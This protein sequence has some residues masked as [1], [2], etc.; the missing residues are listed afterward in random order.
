MSY[1]FTGSILSFGR[2]CSHFSE[3][4]WAILGRKWAVA[5]YP[6]YLKSKWIFV[7]WNGRTTITIAI[8]QSEWKKI[9]DGVVTAANRWRS[10]KYT[11]VWCNRE[12][13]NPAFTQAI[14]AKET[15]Y[16]VELFVFIKL[17]QSDWNLLATPF[18]KT[19]VSGARTSWQNG[20]RRRECTHLS[21]NNAVGK[22]KKNL[23]DRLRKKYPLP[24]RAADTFYPRSVVNH[25]AQSFILLHDHIPSK[26][27]WKKSNPSFATAADRKYTALQYY[28][29]RDVLQ[30]IPVPVLERYVFI[31]CFEK[32]ISKHWSSTVC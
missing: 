5:S 25:R 31:T 8:I 10:E 17:L 9:N 23:R 16:L 7:W 28:Q 11:I 3:R 27:L 26:T 19:S 29:S 4:I 32:E 2:V 15:W 30:K 14:P 1:K 24:V 13:L 22:K 6:V 20:R 21:A 12:S 18:G